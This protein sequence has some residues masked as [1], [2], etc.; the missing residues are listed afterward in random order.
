MISTEKTTERLVINLSSLNEGNSSSF[1]AANELQCEYRT[2]PHVPV[3]DAI[4]AT[5]PV[6]WT[7][8]KNGSIVNGSSDVQTVINLLKFSGI[9]FRGDIRCWNGRRDPNA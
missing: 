8:D 7:W 1:F 2:P 3:P 9:R 6:E 5:E 4:T